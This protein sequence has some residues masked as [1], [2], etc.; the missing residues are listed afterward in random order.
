MKQAL[1]N[2]PSVADRLFSVLE[3]CAYS[4]GPLTLADLVERTGLPKTTLHRTCWKLV[5]LGALEHD[6]GGAGFRI[7]T[8]LFALG[9]MSPSL[10]RLRVTGMPLLHELVAVTGAVANLAV[11]SDRRALLVEEVFG[12]VTTSMAKMVGAT[13]PLHATAI[14]KALL[15]GQPE[16]TFDDI[17]GDQ[18][19]RPFTRNTIV[20]PNLLREH[21][22]VAARSGLA[23]SRGEWR[24][25]TAGVAAPIVVDGETVAAVALLG[26]FSDAELNRLGAPV[27]VV[28]QRFARALVQRRVPVAA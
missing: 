5:E 13:M 24:L 1:T 12:P 2:G 9:G 28:A 10:R 14:G 20:R 27:R 21:L 23:V 4:T 22:A 3:S 16:E 11:L 8:K 19:L 17:V 25:G 26:K 6:D 7:G 15:M 18:L